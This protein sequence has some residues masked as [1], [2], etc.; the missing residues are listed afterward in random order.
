MSGAAIL[1]RLVIALAVATGSVAATARAPARVAGAV[2]FVPD[3]D[4]LWLQPDGGGRPH[5]LRIEGI[6]APEI[7][8]AGGAASREALARRVLRRHVEAEVRRYDDYG[9]GVARI[10][11]DGEDLGGQLVREG[12]A[13]SYRWRHSPGPY[14]S[15]EQVARSARRGLFAEA[16][17]ELPRDFRRRHGPCHVPRAAAR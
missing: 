10:R 5:K 14:A 1:G 4:T 6:D 9:R 2:I 8:Q 16:D 13:W 17:P 11:L 12:Q 7:C 15:Q 3:G